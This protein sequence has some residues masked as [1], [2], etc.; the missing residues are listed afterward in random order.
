MSAPGH[1]LGLFLGLLNHADVEEGALGQVVPLAVAD[2]LEAADRVGQGRV[3]T[4]LV[5]EDLGDEERLRE[6]PLDPSGAV[7]N[8]LVLFGKLVD[9]ENRD[10]VAELSVAL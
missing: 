2:F 3:L 4:F 5:R 9:A 7:D 6:K 8:D 10:D 1:L